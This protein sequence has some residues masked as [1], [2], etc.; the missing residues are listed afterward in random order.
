MASSSNR[1]NKILVVIVIVLLVALIGVIVYKN[2]FGQS[3]AA[4]YL[5]TGD[6]YFGKITEFPNFGLKN[7][8]LIQPTGNEQN[9]LS[10]QKFANVFWGPQDYININRNEVVWTAKL[11]KTSQLLQLMKNSNL[12]AQPPAVQNTPPSSGTE[13][14]SQTQPQPQPEGN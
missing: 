5:K 8:Y 11:S 7:V 3:F 13:A 9:P 4:V 6:L 10:I 1:L 14:Q 2:F 12:G